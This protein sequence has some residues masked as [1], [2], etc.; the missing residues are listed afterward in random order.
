MGQSSGTARVVVVGC[1]RWGRNHV[2][3]Y[4][5]L[6]AL[7]GVVDRHPERAAAMAEAHGVPALSLEDAIGSSDVS[8][9][10]FAL[11]PSQNLPLGLRVLEAGKH[12]FVEKPLA[13]SVSEG[14]R[15][16]AAA[17][18]G[19]RV[20][21]VGHILRYHPA[22]AALL[23]LV[24]GGRLGR[25]RSIVSTRLDLGAIRREEDALWALAP[26]DVSMVLALTG[27]E[28]D[29][30]SAFGGYHT[31]SDIADT[32]TL[33]LRFPGGAAAEIR[34]SWLHPYKEQRLVVVG[35][36][37]MAV[38][39]DRE[40]WPRKLAFHPYRIVET[41]GT[42]LIERG[43]PEAVPVEEGEPLRLECRQF[44]RSIASGEP[45]PTDGREALR[46]L[47]VLEAGSAAL[48]SGCQATSP[49]HYKA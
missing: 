33:A 41:G 20:L 36:E 43:E 37:A 19:R 3:N 38:F 24:H 39:D 12:L 25:V 8:G 11:P 32:A 44:L 34:S 16:C 40:P 15:L 2:R 13:L 42:A 4:A 10:V 35:T 45:P 7:A 31:H 23:G 21:M 47:R 22:F 6:G 1:G 17:E 30:V 9:I 48:L 5:E 28:P 26:H 29:R 46:V 14:A 27:A 49:Q 18:A